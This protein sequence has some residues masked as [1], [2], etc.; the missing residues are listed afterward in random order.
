MFNSTEIFKMVFRIIEYQTSVYVVGFYKSSR[1]YII[2]TVLVAQAKHSS[3]PVSADD[4]PHTC[5]PQ[6]NLLD[7]VEL[8]NTD[9]SQEWCGFLDTTSATTT[10]VVTG[11]STSACV[12]NSTIPPVVTAANSHV[13]THTHHDSFTSNNRGNSVQDHMTA[14][15]LPQ[16]TGNFRVNNCSC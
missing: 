6:D 16:F 10:T 12:S 7:S 15:S 5:N 8:F 1:T 3:N 14:S 4:T 13:V 2:L 11:P 9:V